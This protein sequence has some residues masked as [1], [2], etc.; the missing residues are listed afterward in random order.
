MKRVLSASG[1]RSEEEAGDG[2]KLRKKR[3]M[4]YDCRK[5][6]VM[7][8]QQRRRERR[9]SEKTESERYIR[10]LSVALL[11]DAEAVGD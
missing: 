3:V 8:E 6:E 5:G 2:E 9:E 4:R 7:W 11:S 10:I 1:R